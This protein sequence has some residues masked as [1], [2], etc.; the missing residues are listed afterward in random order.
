M[1]QRFYE[2]ENEKRNIKNL[3]RIGIM[4]N[5]KDKLSTEQETTYD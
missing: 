1:V 5:L 4:H 3:Y 2:K